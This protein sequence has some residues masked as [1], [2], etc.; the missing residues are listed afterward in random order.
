[1]SFLETPRFP[2]RIAYGSA[3]GPEWS[4]TVVQIKS[5][6]TVRNQNWTYPLHRY[7]VATGIKSE[8][9]Y[10]TLLDFFNAVAG[11]ASGFRYKDWRDYK[12]CSIGDTPANDDQTIGT[13]DGAEDDYQIIKTYTA[14]ALSNQRIISKPI[15]GTLVVAVA[16]TAKTETTHYT[17]DYTTGIITFT[18][19]NVPTTGQAVTCGYEFDTPCEFGID[20]LQSAFED[21]GSGVYYYAID[22]IPVQEIRV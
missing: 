15:N 4:T 14:G 16:G 20:Y 18:A 22:D 11:R 21:R 8:D 13:G 3:G 12:S 10:E 9:D 6:R 7:N 19:G 5:G 17:V 1:M 2:D